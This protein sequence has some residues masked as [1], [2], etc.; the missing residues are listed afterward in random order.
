MHATRHELEAPFTHEEIAHCTRYEE[1]RIRRSAKVRFKP[2]DTPFSTV[3]VHCEGTSVDTHLSYSDEDMRLAQFERKDA[4]PEVM[5]VDDDF[6]TPQPAHEV[7]KR[8]SRDAWGILSSRT[9]F[10]S[11]PIN[12]MKNSGDEPGRV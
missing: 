6:A 7:H 8:E 5:P 3:Q 11:V 4:V 2:V 12:L 9:Y 10:S 1:M